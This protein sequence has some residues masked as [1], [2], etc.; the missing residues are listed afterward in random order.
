MQICGLEETTRQG[1]ARAAT[2]HKVTT[3]PRRDFYFFTFFSKIRVAAGAIRPKVNL[4]QWLRGVATGL[5]CQL[6]ST[7]TRD[8]GGKKV[9]ILCTRTL[10]NLGWKTPSKSSCSCRNSRFWGKKDKNNNENGEYLTKNKHS[11]SSC[12]CRNSGFCKEK[13]KNNNENVEKV[14]KVTGTSS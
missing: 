6:A 2:C 1:F 12:G 11:K 5:L 14:G 8:F 3:T 7:T 9:K 13:E 4:R 10:E